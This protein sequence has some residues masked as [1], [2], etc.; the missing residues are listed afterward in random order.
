MWVTIEI[1]VC[2][3]PT[4]DGGKLLYTICWLQHNIPVAMWPPTRISSNGGKFN[5]S[6]LHR[7]RHISYKKFDFSSNGR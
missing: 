4:Y 5:K 1:S 7:F 3:L 2:P 6:A